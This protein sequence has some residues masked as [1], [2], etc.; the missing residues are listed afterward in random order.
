MRLL[1]ARTIGNGLA[2]LAYELVRQ[3]PLPLWTDGQ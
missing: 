3:Y 1:D 2:H